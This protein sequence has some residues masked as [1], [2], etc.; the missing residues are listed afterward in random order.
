PRHH[1]R[2]RDPQHAAG[3]P[4]FRPLRFL[5]DRGP[6]R[7]GPHRRGG[8]YGQDLR[9]ARGRADLGLCDGAVRLRGRRRVRAVVAGGLVLAA[10]AWAGHPSPAA[11]AGSSVSGGGST[12]AAPEIQD[13]AAETGQQPYNLTVNYAVS[14]SGAGRDSYAQ[15]AYQYG[16]SDI[17]FNQD[18]GS[19]QQQAA[20]QHPFD[21]VTV[22]AGGL[23]FMYNV[24]VG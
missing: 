12:F 17:V 14:G 8:T 15:G 7:A 19:L 9:G 20:S 16:A 1:H 11:A 3:P 22:S 23:A 2:D 13:F 10:L 5:H 4:G 18:D 6:G 24:V 21:Y